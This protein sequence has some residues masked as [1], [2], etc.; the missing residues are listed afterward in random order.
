MPATHPTTPRPDALLGDVVPAFLTALA[1]V[2][3]TYGALGVTSNAG[4]WA[5]FAGSVAGAAA[6]GALLR[7]VV[8][9]GLALVLLAAGG[10]VV[11][12]L[13]GIALVAAVGDPPG[14]GTV[15]L[16]AGLPAA[17]LSAV[18][19][20][21]VL[22]RVTAGAL[23]VGGSLLLVV[24]LGIAA[25]PAVGEALEGARDEAA[26]IA[27]LEASGLSPYRPEIGDLDAE[28]SS[29]SVQDDRIVGYSYRYEVDAGDL[30]S[31]Y[32]AVDVLRELPDYRD[33]DTSAQAIYDCREGDG[34]YV[35]GQNGSDEYVVATHGGT[36]LIARYVEGSDRLPDADT[37][38]ADLAGAEP[39]DWGDVVDAD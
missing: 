4:L 27:R 36:F 19:A 17:A 10:Y 34:Y 12:V 31:P 14:N 1:L 13:A 38:G 18:A 33:C 23:P 6:V 2:L 39:V 15:A 9:D 30:N 20:A 37:I 25:A 28:R 22:R 8:A 35:L 21:A 16:L 3:P 32:L 7:L 26:D 5:W 24:L 29:Y 11:L